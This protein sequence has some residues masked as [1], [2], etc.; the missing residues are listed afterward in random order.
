ME[1]AATFRHDEPVLLD[2]SHDDYVNKFGKRPWCWGEWTLAN[3]VLILDAVFKTISFYIGRYV[4][5]K[6]MGP[7]GFL[8]MSGFVQ[9]ASVLRAPFVVLNRSGRF[10]WK[11][12]AGVAKI[13]GKALDLPISLPATGSNVAGADA[14]HPAYIVLKWFPEML[15]TLLDFWVLI[16]ERLKQAK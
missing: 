1:A 5:E 7:M 3:D 6:S 15:K 9:G 8:I 11:A 4:K 10:L 2:K 16:A 14:N 13:V 12:L